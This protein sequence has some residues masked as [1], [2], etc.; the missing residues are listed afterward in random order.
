MANS[1][2]KRLGPYFFGALVFGTMLHAFI[3]DSFIQNVVP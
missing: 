2:T 3:D 1:L